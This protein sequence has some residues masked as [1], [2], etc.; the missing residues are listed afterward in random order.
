MSKNGKSEKSEKSKSKTKRP[1]SVQRNLA[2]AL[3]ALPWAEGQDGEGPPPIWKKLPEETPRAYQ[4]FCVY[5]DM[6]PGRSIRAAA[7]ELGVTERMLYF[8]SSKFRWVNRAAAYDA[9]L[10][11]YA[12]EVR[13]G[14]V[15]RMAARHAQT[16]E[17]LIRA[18]ML[19]AD[20]LV[21]RMEKNPDLV[22]E[23]SNHDL[24]D[25]VTTCTKIAQVIPSLVNV[26][27][28]SQGEATQLI[29]QQSEVLVKQEVFARIDHYKRVFEEVL[30]ARQGEPEPE[31]LEGEFDELDEPE[32]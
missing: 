9:W 31:A 26:E 6:G 14:H 15:Q 29:R 4:A 1:Q 21:R 5:R 24:L 23:L 32:S 8:W 18:L 10:D 19:P 30:R 28:L 3:E 7:E 22:E 12:Q 17:R 11:D 2:K 20:A 16:V 27:R 25:L 13:L